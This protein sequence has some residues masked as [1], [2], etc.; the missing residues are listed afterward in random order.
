VLASVHIKAARSTNAA[1]T[2]AFRN[3]STQKNVCYNVIL[4]NYATDNA[5]PIMQRFAN[6]MY[7]I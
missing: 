5:N 6:V 1:V 7:L 4:V 3:N 2:K